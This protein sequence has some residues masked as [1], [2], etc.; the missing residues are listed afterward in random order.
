M[1]QAAGAVA[2]YGE[3]AVLEL[4]LGLKG[5]GNTVAYRKFAAGLNG[6]L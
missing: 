2:V 5:V 1:V 4:N 3:S 6:D